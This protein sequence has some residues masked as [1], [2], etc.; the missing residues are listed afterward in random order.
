[1]ENGMGIPQ[2]ITSTT[3]ILSSSNPIS[4]YIPKE[5]K[6]GSLEEVFA[7]HVHC[8]IIHNSQE[9]YPSTD[10]WINKMWYMHTVEH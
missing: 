4:R 5:L 10:E 1:M 9:G 3:P 6:A 8:S 7:H 2:K